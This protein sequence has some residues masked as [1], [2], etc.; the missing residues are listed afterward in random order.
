MGL[1]DDIVPAIRTRYGNTAAERIVDAWN[2]G[3]AGE[4]TRKEWEGKGAQVAAS[5]VEGLEAEPWHD[6]DRY[7]WMSSLEKNAAV[8]RDE[9]RSACSDGLG[10]RTTWVPAAEEDAQAYGPGWQ[11]LVLQNRVW[12]SA[13]CEVFPKTCEI[14]Q[15]CG[16]PSNDIFFARQRASS[17]IKPHTDNSNFFVTAHL[18]LEVPDGGGCWI[19]VGT[20]EK[21]EW[22]EHRALAFDS[23][24]VHETRNDALSDRIILLVRFWHP[25]LTQVERNA[26]GFIF[27]AL[28]DPSVLDEPYDSALDLEGVEAGVDSMG[29]LG[30]E[31][32]L[33]ASSTLD[34]GPGETTA[35]EDRDATQAAASESLE[36]ESGGA[37]AVPGDELHGPISVEPLGDAAESERLDG[38]LA[39]LKAEGLLPGAGTKED[40][41]DQGPKNRSERRKASKARKKAVRQG[42]KRKR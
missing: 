4:V 13:A 32:S 25:Q 24:F 36:V 30:A 8:I 6:V 37:L 31:A 26:L 3:M 38:F 33:P 42:K 11:K 39:D 7:P 14:L 21:R 16:A 10:E 41:L 22:H 35:S 12:N 20:N 2:R 17:G 28:D 9:L 40:V 34:G 27:S 5:Y 19:Q 18:P 23:S 1:A 15:S 29:W